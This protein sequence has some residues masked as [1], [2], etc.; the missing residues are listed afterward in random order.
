MK[1]REINTKLLLSNPRTAHS[2]AVHFGQSLPGRS[3]CALLEK[4]KQKWKKKIFWRKKSFFWAKTKIKQV[5]KKLQKF[6]CTQQTWKTA[7]G[8][9]PPGSGKEEADIFMS[10]LPPVMVFCHRSIKLYTLLR[11]AARTRRA[12]HRDKLKRHTLRPRVWCGEVSCKS[13]V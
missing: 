10:G 2:W 11:E 7:T 3:L 5:W 12:R 8:S 13:I 6:V 1:K 4:I 9:R